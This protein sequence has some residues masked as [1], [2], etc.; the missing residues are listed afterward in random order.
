M[1]TKKSSGLSENQMIMMVP[2]VGLELTS[3]CITA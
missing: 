3:L 1:G 2:A